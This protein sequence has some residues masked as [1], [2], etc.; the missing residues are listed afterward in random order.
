MWKWFLKLARLE[1]GIDPH[2]MLS[3][4]CAAG[5]AITASL[6]DT[7]RA[8]QGNPDSQIFTVSDLLD[9][10]ISLVVSGACF[11]SEQSCDYF[12]QAAQALGVDR[13]LVANFNLGDMSQLTEQ[14]LEMLERAL[15][16]Q[17][18]VDYVV[19]KLAEQHRYKQPKQTLPKACLWWSYLSVGDL[20]H[21]YLR[22]LAK[23]RELDREKDSSQGWSLRLPE[24]PVEAETFWSQAALALNIDLES[25]QH[26]NLADFSK[27]KLNH[28]KL[29][30][31]ALG[32]T[33]FATR[34]LVN[35]YLSTRSINRKSASRKRRS[36]TGET[37]S[38]GN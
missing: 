36:I 25:V 38:L 2:P 14:E 1:G 32:N 9:W 16:N 33:S 4:D 11:S 17:G 34:V 30:D 19:A 31:L 10:F 13:R 37:V 26:F 7:K 23:Q 28:L 20:Y 29:I 12:T 24:P 22:D 6:I 18:F 27:L 35:G 5:S 8:L 21:L 15:F 3:K